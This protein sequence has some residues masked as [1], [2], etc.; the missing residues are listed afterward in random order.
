MTLKKKFSLL[1]CLGGHRY[2]EVVT[3][4]MPLHLVTQF[5][6]KK[7]QSQTLLCATYEKELSKQS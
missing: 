7:D 5:H 1:A 4:S 2:L 3:R 6:G